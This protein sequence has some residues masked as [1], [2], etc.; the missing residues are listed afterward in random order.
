MWSCYVR[1]ALQALW[2]L[3][4]YRVGLL[5][6]TDMTGGYSEGPEEARYP[7]VVVPNDPMPTP[8]QRVRMRRNADFQVHPDDLSEQGL[9]ET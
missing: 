2:W 4:L 5:N 8:S 9:L 3:H 1:R 6:A 7:F